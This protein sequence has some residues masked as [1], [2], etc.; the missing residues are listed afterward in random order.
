MKFV[1]GFI[2][3]LLAGAAGNF[4][5]LIGLVELAIWLN[6]TQH[7][8]LAPFFTAGRLYVYYALF[9]LIVYLVNK[10]RRVHKFVLGLIVAFPLPVIVFA[11]LAAN[12]FLGD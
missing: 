5:L 9:L 3:G 12:D 2:V 10:R 7:I 8:D 6:Q 4:F 1:L 11:Y